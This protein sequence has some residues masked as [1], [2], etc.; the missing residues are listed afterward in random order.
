MAGLSEILDGVGEGDSVIVSGT[1]MLREG[2]KARVVEP[3]GD[4]AP[5][6]RPLDSTAA[7]PDSAARRG[8]RGGGGGE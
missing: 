6:A 7:R 4:Q 5:A 2:G 3:L 8:R 1:N